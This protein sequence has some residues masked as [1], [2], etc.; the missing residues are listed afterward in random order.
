[1]T[2]PVLLADFGGFY[3]V[4]LGLF[5][6]LANYL[7]QNK[8]TTMQIKNIFKATDGQKY[9]KINLKYKEVAGHS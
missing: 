3:T 2:W 8:W 5:Y 7:N 6:Y 1:M 4:F 9:H